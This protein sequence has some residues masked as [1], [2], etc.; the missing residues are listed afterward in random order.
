[1]KLFNLNES[2]HRNQKYRYAIFS[3]LHI[4]SKALNKQALDRDLS[5][6][7][8][9][10]TKVIING[11]TLDLILMQDHKRAMPSQIKNEDGQINKYV[12][13]AAELLLPYVSQ[14]CIIGTGNH[15]NSIT[16][17][18]GVDVLAW[19]IDKLNREKTNGKIQQGHYQNFIRINFL[20]PSHRNKFLCSYD[21]FLHHFVGGSSP[22][23]K[24]MIDFNRIITA[25]Q[26]D[27]YIGSHK[28]NNFE[29]SYPL[30]YITPSG[31]IE[32]KDRKAVMTPPY[33]NPVNTGKETAWTDTFYGRQALP[34][35]AKLELLP[36][37]LTYNN[38]V[39]Y[40]LKSDVH[41]ISNGGLME[42]ESKIE[43][44]TEV[45]TLVRSKQKEIQR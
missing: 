32:T 12:D 10:D 16:K 3:D 37:K 26:A 40:K 35:Y 21:I 7:K 30:T 43:F 18:H 19:L 44:P 20:D 2:Y 13:E 36:Y 25:N 9:D 31:R 41:I 38:Q 6:C 8:R 1:M 34:G 14:L 24:G 17:H 11:D 4:G 28:H 39:E 22:V 42:L 5:D 23:T 45:I 27:L 15:E 29:T 33:T